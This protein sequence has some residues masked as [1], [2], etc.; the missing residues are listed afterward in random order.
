MPLRLGS[1]PLFPVLDSYSARQPIAWNGA[2]FVQHSLALVNRELTLALLDTPTFTNR[3]DLHIDHYEAA[4]PAL[5][6]EARFAP[7]ASRM[8]ASTDTPAVTVRHRW[9]PE[10]SRPDNGKLVLIQP[11]EFGSLPRHWVSA[12]ERGA[13]EI[14][15]PSQFVRDSYITSGVPIE[16]M[17][18]VPNG[19][20]TDVFHP[21]KGTGNW[22]LG[23]QKSHSPLS[24]L[25]SPLYKFL[26][27]GGTIA[28]KGIDILLDAYDRAFT[29]QDPVVLIVKDF[30]TDSFY[31]NQGAGALIQALQA[32]PN[33]ARIV[34]LN[35]DMSEVELAGLYVS[36]DC[37]VHPYR[38]EGYGLPIA[39]AMACG[40]PAIVTDYGAALDFANASNSY[41][42]P[43]EAQRM[44]EKRVGNMPTVDYPFWANPNREALS[45]L[46]R[47]VVAHPDE[48]QAKGIQAAQDIAAKHTWRHAAQ[49]ANERLA[50]L[51]ENIEKEKRRKGE[52]ET[53]STMPSSL[54]LHPSSL[55]LG[56]GG[57]SMSGGLNLPGSFSVPGMLAA[58]EMYEERKQA[59]LET[60]RRGAWQ[61]AVDALDA[62]LIERPDD[63]D[64]VNAL[65]VACH[66]MGDTPRAL[67]L[68]HQGVAASPNSRDFHHN[69]GFVLLSEGQPEEALENVLLALAMTPDDSSLRRTV[70]RAQTAVLHKARTLL[71]NVP[72]KQRA[73]IKRSSA[74]RELMD[75]YDRANQALG[76]GCRA[77]GKKSAPNTQHL[78]LSCA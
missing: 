12:I 41:L 1:E 21:G 11:W 56:L 9:P 75:R 18:V 17:F 15:V 40:K 30:G 48:A 67:E 22:E 33:G 49:I 55:P 47:H 7:L 71:R 62:C 65:A 61:Q 8:S 23:T 20:N 14:W 54:I 26:F 28:R 69:L 58:G 59:A 68:L 5:R 74:Y 38:G 24:T 76:V 46:L 13:D 66:R 63:W 29:A 4:L 19:V 25:H 37:L 73:T 3:F 60:A 36:C 43:A 53:Q 45:E 44:T 70:E 2:F 57:L 31:A 34:Y 6:N 50:A 27:V 10:F 16:K 64:V 72:N 32:K 77:L 39:E 42:I 78:S 51:C 52:E 35:E